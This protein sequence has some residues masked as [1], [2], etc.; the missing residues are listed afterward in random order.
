MCKVMVTG[1]LGNVG[2]YVAAHL[3][4]L[5]QDVVLAGIRLEPLLQRYGNAAE[6]LN[7][8]QTIADVWSCAM[9]KFLFIKI[10]KR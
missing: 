7:H 6:S 2:G 3:L 1:A 9:W 5:G 4:T 8:A 10:I